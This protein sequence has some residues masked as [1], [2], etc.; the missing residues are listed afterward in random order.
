LKATQAAARWVVRMTVL[1]TLAGLGFTLWFW[2]VV[3]RH[4]RRWRNTLIQAMEDR[5]QAEAALRLSQEQLEE[6]VRQRTVALS[7]E[8]AERKQAEEARQE[9]EEQFQTICAAAHDAIIIMDNDGCISFWNAAAER[10]FGLSQPEALGQNLHELLTPAVY[11]K[12]QQPAMTRWNETGQGAAVGKTAELIARRKN[13]AEFPIELSLSA[14]KGSGRWQ[15]IGIVRDITKRKEAEA[16]LAQA[17]DAALEATRQ[18][19]EFLANM[20]HEIRTPMNGIIGMANLLLDTELAPQQRHFANT[21]NQSGESLLALVNN[22]LDF[23]KMEA[24]KLVFETLDFDLHEVL[25]NTFDLVTER[26]QSKNLELAAFVPAEVPTRLRGDPGRLRQV[27]LNLV[28][29]ALKFTEHG[30]V[31][32]RLTKQGETPTHATLCFEV[33]DTGMGISLEGQRRLFQAFSQADESIQ[34]NYG[35]TGLGLAISKQLVELMGGQIGVESEL[36]K[37]TTFWFT[38]AWEKQPVE[39]VPGRKDKSDLAS[40][41]V[42]IVDDNASNREILD[43]QTRAWKMRPTCATGPIEALRLLRAAAA[44]PYA[45][46]LLDMQ[47]P[48]MD[49]LSLAHAIK[50][51]PAIAVTRL[52]LL[53][54]L[55]QKLDSATLKAAG[56][57]ACLTKPVRQTQLFDCLAAVTGRAWPSPARPLLPSTKTAVPVRPWRILLAD[58]DVINQQVAL[59]QLRKLGLTA[60]VAA[61]GLAVLAALEQDAYDVILMDCQMPQMDGLQ[62]TQEIRQRERRQGH[63]PVHIIAMT[64][65]V[66]PGDRE[67]CLAAGMN[68]YIGKPVRQVELEQALD[69]CV[70]DPGDHGQAAA[71][72]TPRLS[73]EPVITP[74]VAAVGDATLPAS[75]AEES[76]VDWKRFHEIAEDSPEGARQLSALYLGQADN[77]M[78]GIQAAIKADASQD[79]C[80]L[81]HRLGGSSSACGMR[82]ILPPLLELEGQGRRGR[83]SDADQL[84]AQTSRKL[85]SIRRVLSDQ[86]AGQP[87]SL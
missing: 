55:G 33:K 22:I 49:G 7:A 50:A 63:R 66:M 76:P 73:A 53:T 78:N 82:A 64:A 52:V 4:L 38:A 68:D 67:T 47:M 48:E 25:E 86:L 58:D 2:A 40:L 60:K 10:I 15:A 21:I 1:G 72:L 32:V 13:G 29:N 85:E 81:A 37:G 19:A 54:S 30:E 11:R 70:C 6:R 45:V 74:R 5:T 44:E 79:L 28:G 77:L 20:S 42:L 41:R 62:T 46:A 80:Q 59:G 35:G 26:A 61:D 36:G 23:S 24:R 75:G 56:I 83:L 14:L 57:E 51:D 17:R 3:I 18:K 27:L 8:I 12:K 43:H 16:E 65:R 69:R 34:R 31:I 87:A 71:S 9:K 84:F 39:G